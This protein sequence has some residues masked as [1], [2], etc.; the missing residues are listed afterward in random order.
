[1]K[2]IVLLHP[3]G[4]RDFTEE[5]INI[6]PIK[7]LCISCSLSTRVCLKKETKTLE[8]RALEYC[9]YLGYL[10]LPDTQQFQTVLIWLNAI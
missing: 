3:Q 2:T 5:Q 10:K 1:M 7:P 9:K 6:S 4:F 8:L